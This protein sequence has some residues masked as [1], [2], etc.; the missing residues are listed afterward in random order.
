[1]TLQESR[2]E[3]A[4]KEVKKMAHDNCMLE[5]RFIA[6]QADVEHL[7]KNAKMDKDREKDM[8][9]AQKKERNLFTAQ[10]KQL[11]QQRQEL[12]G[13]YKN[14]LLLLDN[15]KRQNMCLEQGKLIQAVERDFIKMLN[16]K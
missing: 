3:D 2:L 14:Q 11:G 12:I 15:L 1:M 5:K 10:I 8:I 16:Y 9:D 4:S 7:Q 6:A 13:A